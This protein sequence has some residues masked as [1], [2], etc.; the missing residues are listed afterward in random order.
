MKKIVI[1]SLFVLIIVFG[2]NCE[3]SFASNEVVASGNVGTSQ[4]KWELTEDGTMKISKGL[5]EWYINFSTYS[6][7]GN[8]D[9]VNN[10][11]VRQD[12]KR[13]IFQKGLVAKN[14][15]ACF[16]N[17]TNLEYIDFSNM[18]TSEVRN[19]SNMFKGC[20]SLKRLDL[21]SFDASKVTDMHNMFKDCESLEAI[22]LLYFNTRSVLSMESMFEGCR[23]LNILELRYFNT[24]KVTSM[25][26]MFKNCYLLKYIL[27]DNFNTS[28]VRDMSEMFMGCS[29]LEYFLIGSF[30]T[31]KVEN[32]YYM[33]QGCK[34]LESLDLRNFDTS[35]V[36]N[37]GGM[38]HNCSS[39]KSLNISKLNTSNVE[40]M[41]SMF[42]NCKSLEDIDTSSFDT[43]RSLY[44]DQMFKN[45]ESLL[46]LD[47]SNFTYDSAAGVGNFIEG[48]KSLESINI[49]N[50]GYNSRLFSSD[51]LVNLPKLKIVSIGDK[52]SIDTLYEITNGHLLSKDAQF[53]IGKPPVNGE[54]T[55]KW[56]AVG[57]GSIN[58]PEGKSYTVDEIG[59][60]YKTKLGRGETYV[61]EKK[62]S[63]SENTVAILANGY[64]YTDV[65]AATV[66]ANELNAPILLTSKDNISIDTM[67]EIERLSIN[68]NRIIIA[69][70]TNS[71][72]Q[73]VLDK[74]K[75]IKNFTITRYS[76]RDRYETAVKIGNKV[77]E[78][79]SKYD[80][81][82]DMAIL[83]NGKNFPDIITMSA[84]ARKMNTPILITDPKILPK[85]TLD[86]MKTWNVNKV[87]IGGKGGSVSYDIEKKVKSLKQGMVVERIGGDDR[88]KTASLIGIEVRKYTV[89]QKNM[90]LV[91][92]TNYPDGITSTILSKK[93]DAPI[94]ITTP[95]KLS[96]IT[97]NDIK[98]WGIENIMVVGGTNSVSNGIYNNLK[99]KNKERVFGTNRYSTAV[100]I[101]ERNSLDKPIG[102]K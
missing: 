12:T 30:N 63:E 47:I 9:W 11:Q 24:S 15:G 14:L 17:F 90:I 79:T 92:G 73:K 67:K 91:D 25:S 56:V 5:N 102:F 55:G 40:N 78:L 22:N 62:P 98:N 82:N 50:F 10:D 43:S 95:D 29:S 16:E 66:L 101:S 44:F 2:F 57:K 83:V 45:C 51:F 4:C 33:F 74:L 76:G 34:K 37:M 69:G 38:F 100:K 65:L 32:M 93:F 70:G 7:N 85:S 96:Q 84:L 13:V 75:N 52:F 61:W 49:G 46:S 68:K 64:N 42:Y 53:T 3:K 23:S 72:S 18:D 86:A 31:S 94:H 87:V 20:K 58:K 19:M 80:I 41:I 39:L 48:C 60:L 1:L 27:F 21:R 35:K 81:G 99:V 77:R 8:Y 26:K 97:S 59:K 28:E 89:G 71:V 88:Y 6:G 36:I 54:Y